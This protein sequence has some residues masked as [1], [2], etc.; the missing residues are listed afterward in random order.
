MD[1]KNTTDTKTISKNIV[2]IVFV[3]VGPEAP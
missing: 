3:V 2:F 1:T